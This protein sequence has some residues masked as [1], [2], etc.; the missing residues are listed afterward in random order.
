M[1][2]LAELVTQQALRQKARA[3]NHGCG[4]FV[5]DV[6]RCPCLIQHPQPWLVALHPYP[7]IQAETSLC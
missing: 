4:C 6:T 2:A 1:F 3:R 5:A 7:W